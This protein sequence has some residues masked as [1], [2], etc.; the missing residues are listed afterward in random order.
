MLQLDRPLA[1]LLAVGFSAS[2]LLGELR[3]VALELLSARAQSAEIRLECTRTILRPLSA[4]SLDVDRIT[5][6]SQLPLTP[7]SLRHSA[8]T[9]SLRLREL[10][11]QLSLQLLSTTPKTRQIRLQRPRTILRPPSAQRLNLNHI[12]S[13][14]QLPLP[15]QS[16]RHS[17]VTS[18]LNI[19]EPHLRRGKTIIELTRGLTRALKHLRLLAGKRLELR[20]GQVAVCSDALDLEGLRL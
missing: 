8:I 20:H 10:R 4:R 6:S 18:S 7:R 1:D 2:E 3:T 16:L 5:K 9:G 17:A 12:P 13:R 19:R 14:S 15:H 11:P